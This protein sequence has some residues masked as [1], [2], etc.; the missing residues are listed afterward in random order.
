M[1]GFDDGSS[2]LGARWID[3]LER[4]SG[5]DP[6]RLT[7]GRNQARRH[8]MRPLVIDRGEARSED[9]RVEFER[10]TS[11]RWRQVLE[12]L[13]TKSGHVA[14]L[15]DGELS[16]AIL[17]EL[18][19]AGIELFATADEIASSCRCDEWGDPCRHAAAVLYRLATEFD[20]DPLALV[21]LRGLRRDD[22]AALWNE[23]RGIEPQPAT[24]EEPDAAEIWAGV[25]LAEAES[26]ELP[27]MPAGLGALLGAPELLAAPDSWEP[28]LAA[29]DPIDPHSVDELALDATE[30]AWAVLADGASAGLVGTVHGDLARRAANLQHTPGMAMLASRTRQSVE[31]LR[32]WAAAWSLGG[33]VAVEVL[34]EPRSRLIDQRRLAEGRDALVEMGISKRTVALNYDSL[35]MPGGVKL[36]IGA[37]GRWYRL[38][39]EP[40]VRG[41]PETWLLV[42]P[43][44]YEVEDLVG[45]DEA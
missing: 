1:T 2:S 7:A 26:V 25:S 10:F 34:A 41:R 14:A 13:G 18:A 28:D 5:I 45:D 39:S 16:S 24:V 30:R 29:K 4:R 23:L 3:W 38:R 17:D 31:T 27:P 11:Q 33:D 15:L 35:G 36:V 42:G 9:T 6:T 19:D 22:L 8:P 40:G 20:S 12:V 37:D 44:S 32:S 43:G 21:T